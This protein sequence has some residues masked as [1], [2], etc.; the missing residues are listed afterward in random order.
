[1]EA[2]SRGADK[3]VLVEKDYGKR[4]FIEKN[5]DAVHADVNIYTL[6][7]EKFL[8]KAGEA[9]NII[10][11]DPPF[12]YKEKN[13]LLLSLTESAAVSKDSEIIIHFPQE[14]SLDKEVNGY[15]VYKEKKYGRSLV[16][17][18]RKAQ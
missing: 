8:K 2:A 17:F 16:W 7:A 13:K 11:L 4:I 6:P 15:T 1:M 9:F 14:D 3:I 12:P 10:F 5:A 18:Y